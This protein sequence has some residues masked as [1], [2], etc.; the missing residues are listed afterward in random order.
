MTIVM[1]L[2]CGKSNPCRAIWSAHRGSHCTEPQVP[3]KATEANAIGEQR[4]RSTN[5]RAQH[6]AQG[7]TARSHR[8]LPALRLRHDRAIRERQ[9]GRGRPG[10]H[11]PA[12]GI[13]PHRDHPGHTAD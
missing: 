7:W 10:Q 6:L 2:A 8:F 13:R 4:R 3:I 1:A 5:G 11:H 9:H 12:P